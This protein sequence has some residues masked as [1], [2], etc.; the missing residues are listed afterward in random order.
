M[1]D[2]VNLGHRDQLLGRQEQKLV[3]R[4]VKRSTRYREVIA[5]YLEDEAAERVVDRATAEYG[6]LAT[7]ISGLSNRLL[8]GAL[9]GTYEYLAYGKA[10]KAEGLTPDDIGEIYAKVYQRLVANVPLWIVKPV[11]RLARPLLRWKLRRDA[12]TLA[13]EPHRDGNWRYEVVERQPGVVDFGF[14][15]TSCAVCS[16]YRRHDAEDLVVHL[17]ALDDEMSRALDLGLRRTG[18]RARGDGCCDFRYLLGGE[19]RELDSVRTLTVIE[20]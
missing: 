11:V 20:R 6:S 15:I 9:A 17:C 19:P 5:E 13:S 16:L 7:E 10:L 1:E 18:T 8:D 4:F 12:A 14:D 2:P 3:R